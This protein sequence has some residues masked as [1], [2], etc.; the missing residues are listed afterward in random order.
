M[1][2][3]LASDYTLV[4]TPADEDMNQIGDAGAKLEPRNPN[5]EIRNQIP[6]ARNP[7]PETR[8]PKS[9]TRNQKPDR[10]VPPLH[11]VDYDVFNVQAVTFDFTSAGRF[12]RFFG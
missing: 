2:G 9:E 5:P 10:R 11:T 3:R 7:K 4:P 12:S 8:H 1:T 6:E